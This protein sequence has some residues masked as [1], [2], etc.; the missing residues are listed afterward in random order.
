[1]PA[2]REY[3]GWLIKKRGYYYRPNWCG[4]TANAAEAGRYT[5]SQADRQAAVEPENFTIVPAPE[6][7]PARFTTEYLTRELAFN[8]G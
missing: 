2:D 3:A 4:Y 5:R 7:E 8:A 1:M 6:C